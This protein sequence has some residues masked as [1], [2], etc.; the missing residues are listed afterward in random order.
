M[1]LLMLFLAVIGRMFRFV[2]WGTAG[3]LGMA[4]P[5]ARHTA[6]WQRMHGPLRSLIQTQGHQSPRLR[7]VSIRQ[8]IV[9]ASSL[10]V[11]ACSGL[12]GLHRPDRSNS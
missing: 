9:P 11:T 7:V 1:G 10:I 3:R 4:G 12:L 5:W 2:V 8:V 6:H